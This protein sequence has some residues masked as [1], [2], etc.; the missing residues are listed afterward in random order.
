V[1]Q[2]DMTLD[3]DLTIK[4]KIKSMDLKVHEIVNTEIGKINSDVLNML[5]GIIETLLELTINTVLG[6]GI[7]IPSIIKPLEPLKLTD[8]N[9]YLSEDYIAIEAF[10]DFS[11]NHEGYANLFSTDGL[12]GT[13]NSFASAI[14]SS[15]IHA[16]N[17]TTKEDTKEYLQHSN[18]RGVKTL[19][20]SLKFVE[21][22]F[23]IGNPE[24]EIDTNLSDL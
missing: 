22:A 19:Y 12:T 20:K 7:N 9:L 21:T 3:G 14:K 6:I 15:L 23:N 18:L 16:A 13:S 5:M 1:F 2:G 10:P 11:S 17:T 8:I 24:Y 4:G